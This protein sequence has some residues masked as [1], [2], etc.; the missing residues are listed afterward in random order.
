MSHPTA[1]QLEEI[2]GKADEARLKQAHE[3]EV[4]VYV[5]ACMRACVWLI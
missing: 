4:R 2:V 1:A 3:L 5:R